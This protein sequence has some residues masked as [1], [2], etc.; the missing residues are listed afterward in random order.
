MF[1][2]I[3]VNIVSVL[4]SF[5]CPIVKSIVIEVLVEKERGATKEFQSSREGVLVLCSSQYL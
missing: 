3:F 2:N 1:L 5:D 4:Q